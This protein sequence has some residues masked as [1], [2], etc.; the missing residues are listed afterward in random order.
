M[1]L[2]VDVGGGEP[3]GEAGM[4][5]LGTGGMVRLRIERRFEE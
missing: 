4:S 3:G 5:K 1:N 2:A